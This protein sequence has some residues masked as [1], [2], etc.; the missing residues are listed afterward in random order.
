MKIYFD[1]CSIQRPLD[2]KSNIRV[3][4]ESEAILNIIAFLENGV[5][6]IVSSDIL[7]YE[8]DFIKNT[9]RYMFMNNFL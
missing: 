8:M 4:A 2:D 5:I 6:E 9:N 1:T 3:L 7:L